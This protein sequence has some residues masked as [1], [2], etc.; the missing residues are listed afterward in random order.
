MNQNVLI[1]FEGTLLSLK[2]TIYRQASSKTGELH[3]WIS[4]KLYSRQ[5]GEVMGKMSLYY[6][7][8]DEDLPPTS[9]WKQL[10]DGE[11]PTPKLEGVSFSLSSVRAK[12]QLE[13]S[14]KNVHLFSWEYFCLIFEDVVKA[15]DLKVPISDPKKMSI[16]SEVI[17]NKC[18]NF[19]DLYFSPIEVKCDTF[20]RYHYFRVAT[21]D[22][23]LKFGRKQ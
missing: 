3:W 1:F 23:R 14:L 12:V 19:S 7:K 13:A 11:L 6:T 22:P 10:R 16:H 20:F 17:F 9:G 8:S 18:L 4:G 15:P 2:V 21:T 5:G